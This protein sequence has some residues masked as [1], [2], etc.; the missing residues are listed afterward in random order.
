[1]PPDIRLKLILAGV[2]PAVDAEL[3]ADH[4]HIKSKQEYIEF[5]KKHSNIMATDYVIHEHRQTFVLYN[6]KFQK[7]VDNCKAD[8]RNEKAFGKLLG[9]TEPL[10]LMHMYYKTDKKLIDV[11]YT[12]HNECFFGY[13]KMQKNTD[14]RKELQ[15]LE[16]MRKIDNN[17]RLEI[18]FE[19]DP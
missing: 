1:M 6:K 7:L 19:N 4:K 9:Y 10:N 8:K 3:D 5:A 2:L 14:M 11:C 12:L 15:L 16:K 18:V 17:C 13:W